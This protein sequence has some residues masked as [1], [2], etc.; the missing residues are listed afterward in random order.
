MMSKTLPLREQNVEEE[1]D[2]EEE[3]PKYKG[4]LSTGGEE[5]HCVG[6]SQH[7]G[8]I[9]QSASWEK[10]HIIW[11]HMIDTSVHTKMWI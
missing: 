5:S 7:G 11:K 10:K 8:C 2:E 9:A 4:G 1:T 3:G 6:V